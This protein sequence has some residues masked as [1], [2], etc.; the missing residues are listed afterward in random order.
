M[1]PVCAWVREE[2][3]KIKREMTRENG[4]S[5]LDLIKM[6]MVVNKNY[7]TKIDIL[8]QKKNKLKRGS[9]GIGSPVL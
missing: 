9:S 1:T 5:N 6:I 3:A 7:A 8:T 4:N 2:I